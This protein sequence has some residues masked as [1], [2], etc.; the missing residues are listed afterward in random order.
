MKSPSQKES[1][2]CSVTRSVCAAGRPAGR[3]IEAVS[4]MQYDS[5][6]HQKPYA[7]AVV[8]GS[9]CRPIS[10]EAF[11]PYA[12]W[13]LSA[14]VKYLLQNCV[15]QYTHSLF[16]RLMA[17]PIV[18]ISYEMDKAVVFRKIC[19]SLRTGRVSCVPRNATALVWWAWELRGL[20]N[21]QSAR[22]DCRL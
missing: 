14:F 3:P 16:V 18:H 13:Q 1:L 21:S 7:C 8:L 20:H 5:A 2:W 11:Q 15:R 22:G 4:Q 9:G 17:F 19:W 12:L 10:R 6:V